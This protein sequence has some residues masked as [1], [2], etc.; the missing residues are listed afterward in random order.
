M[1]RACLVRL[2][3]R[4][5]VVVWGNRR[6]LLMVSLGCVWGCLRCGW[7]LGG[8]S[9]RRRCAYVGML[10]GRGLSLSGR[11]LMWESL[12]NR[13]LRLWCV[14]LVRCRSVFGWFRRSDL[15]VCMGRTR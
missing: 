4:I 2:M 12:L 9:G 14:C 10:N 15:L 7:L 8:R 6:G 11:R 1:I 5:F 3:S 13:V